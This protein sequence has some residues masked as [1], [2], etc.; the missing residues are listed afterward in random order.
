V[1]LWDLTKLL[2]R[3]WYAFL[4]ML[5]AS[6][7]AV[8]FI[9]QGVKPDYSAV[10]HLQLV[11]AGARVADEKAARPTNPWADLGIPAL[12]NAAV[13]GVQD[14]SVLDRMVAAGLTDNYKVTMDYRETYVSIEAVG[15]SPAQASATVG[16]LMR[17]LADE[18]VSQQERLR[19]A[20]V[21]QIT[22]LPLDRG[23]K[24]TIVASKRNRMFILA[25]G[26]A[27]LVS[28][29]ATVGLDVLLRR[30]RARRISGAAE[31][32][33][34]APTSPAPQARTRGV[35]PGDADERAGGQPLA[36]GRP[37]ADVPTDR[38]RSTEAVHAGAPGASSGSR[39]TARG[40]AHQTDDIIRTVRE[41][42]AGPRADPIELSDATVVLPVS[43]IR[44]TGRDESAEGQL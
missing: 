25:A 14:T 35:V 21:D 8:V 43:R 23:D 26:I 10:G 28:V 37:G 16:E 18:V 3:R 15:N 29:A 24:V 6:S 5:L 36:N 42:G 12:G 2:F 22:T 40:E 34:V 31:A 7:A 39:P 41:A 1:D 4:P 44:R 27:V 33:V 30:R 13:L 11:P 9:S 32:A 20:K 19:V 38:H 17:L